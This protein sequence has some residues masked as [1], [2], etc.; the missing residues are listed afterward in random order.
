MIIVHD[1]ALS[2]PVDYRRWA[3]TLPFQ[4]LTIAGELWQGIA[5]TRDDTL[6]A[7]VRRILPHAQPGLTFF[8]RSPRGQSEP[9]FIHSDETM[10]QWTAILYLNPN[11][12]D[13]D[14]TTFWRHRTSG[15]VRG[16]ASE[17]WRRDR[18][19]SAWEPLRHVPARFN[20][21]LIF[22]AP[23]FHSRGIEENYGE[24]EDARLIQVVFGRYSNGEER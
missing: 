24:G 6:P 4:T 1:V 18:D 2:Q 13:G 10:G 9:N 23:L 11:P 7:C 5:I 3:L 22:D 21:L 15:A 8:R 16:D 17:I 12:E 14:G 20:R 19:R